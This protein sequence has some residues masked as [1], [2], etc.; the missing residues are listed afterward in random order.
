MSV[1]GFFLRFFP[2]KL[3]FVACPV[4]GDTHRDVFDGHVIFYGWKLDK[5]VQFLRYLEWISKAM[6]WLHLIFSALN[7]NNFVNIEAFDQIFSDY[8][9]RSDHDIVDIRNSKCH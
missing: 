7:V 6:F 9:R 1:V 8:V 3:L 2:E 5:Q 4:F